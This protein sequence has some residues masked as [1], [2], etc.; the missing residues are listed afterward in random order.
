MPL[1]PT[2]ASM[3]TREIC[4]LAP[5]IPVLVVEDVFHATSL[6][7]ALVSGGLLGPFDVNGP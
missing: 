4:M 5:I 7:E 6:A 2:E 1:T 3:T